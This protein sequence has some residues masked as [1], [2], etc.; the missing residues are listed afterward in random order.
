MSQFAIR[1]LPFVVAALL[2]GLSVPAR[3]DDAAKPAKP[4][5]VSDGPTVSVV[6]ATTGEVTEQI[7]VTGTLV[8]REELQVTTEIE[9]LGVA[10][11]MAEEGD[12]VT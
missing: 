1:L 11:I 9:G 12:H 3:A 7:I 10:E 5:A 6:T 4:P 2:A 8:P